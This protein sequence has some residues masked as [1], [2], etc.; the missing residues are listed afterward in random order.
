MSCKGR[1]RRLLESFVPGL[2][3]QDLRRIVRLLGQGSKVGFRGFS[4]QAI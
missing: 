2:R 3:V 4:V 1:Q